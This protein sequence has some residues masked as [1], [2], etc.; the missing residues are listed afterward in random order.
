MV[1]EDDVRRIA[2]S[3]P[4]TAEKPS[5]GTSGRPSACAM[6]SIQSNGDRPYA[7]PPL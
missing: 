7:L 5:Y 3:L 4:A 2:L 1:T 6:T